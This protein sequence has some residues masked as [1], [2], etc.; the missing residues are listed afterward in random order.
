MNKQLRTRSPEARQR[1]FGGKAISTLT[2]AQLKEA[3]GGDDAPPS[4]TQRKFE[5]LDMKGD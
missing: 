4:D 2:L 1:V 3:A 5:G